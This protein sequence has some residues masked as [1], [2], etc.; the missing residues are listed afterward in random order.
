MLKAFISACLAILFLVPSGPPARA[1]S[2]DNKGNQDRL[3]YGS[4]VA[5]EK[6]TICAEYWWPKLIGKPAPTPKKKP[7]TSPQKIQPKYFVVSP[8]KPRAFTSGTRTLEI[9]QP[10]TVA[11]TASSHIRK[12][13]L[14]GRLAVVRFTPVRTVWS[15]GDGRRSSIVRPTHSFSSPGSYSARAVV[16]YSVK[17]KFVGTTRWITDPRGISLQTNPLVFRVR[18]ADTKPSAGKPLLVLFNCQPVQRLGC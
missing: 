2:C 4:N 15:F 6:V 9:S 12:N 5:G 13:T 11:T 14:L 17:F 7:P 10:F 16:S 3:H 18:R 1:M 8:L